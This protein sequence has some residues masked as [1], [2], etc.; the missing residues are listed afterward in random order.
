[1]PPIS[2]VPPGTP[3]NF[4]AA[5]VAVVGVAAGVGGT[6]LATS[7]AGVAGVGTEAGGGVAGDVRTADGAGGFV[8]VGTGEVAG[9]AADPKGSLP[10]AGASVIRV[11]ADTSSS[12]ERLTMTTNSQGPARPRVNDGV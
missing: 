10:G 6:V 9:V 2:M 7:V 3:G 11:V 1:M 8:G 12:P 5:A 4:S